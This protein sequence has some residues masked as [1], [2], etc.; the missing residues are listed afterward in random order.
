MCY[1]L[2]E[3]FASVS[4][5]TRMLTTFGLCTKS[6]R[7]RLFFQYSS[8]L[9]RIDALGKTVIFYYSA[10]LTT[11]SS[12]RYQ[13]HTG[14]QQPFTT[15]KTGR[16]ADAREQ[17]QTVTFINNAKSKEETNLRRNQVRPS[18]GITLFL[19]KIIL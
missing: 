11:F 3:V 12:L 8:K 14:T 16:A 1:I 19:T 7:F 13:V 4:H 9:F 10:K 15:M 5:V 2:A 6:Y 18:R 17:P